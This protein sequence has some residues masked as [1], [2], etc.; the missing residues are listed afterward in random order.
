MNTG[1]RSKKAIAELESNSKV[2]DEVMEPEL[3]DEARAFAFYKDITDDH[4]IHPNKSFND[5]IEALRE[6]TEELKQ[7]RRE[8]QGIA[9]RKL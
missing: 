8:I 3:S 5:A 1:K 6:A 4:W 9:A 2:I 7:A